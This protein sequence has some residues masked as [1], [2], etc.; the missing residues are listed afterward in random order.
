MLIDNIKI[1]V[2]GGTGGNGIVAFSKEM[3]C[4]GPTG[5]DG[6]DGGNV[7]LVGVS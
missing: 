7:V 2:A 6:G 3:M 4:S 5:G 1:K